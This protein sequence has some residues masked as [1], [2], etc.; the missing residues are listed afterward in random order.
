MA[1]ENIQGCITWERNTKKI[2]YVG[3]NNKIIEVI[4]MEVVD[5]IAIPCLILYIGVASYFIFIYG[6]YRGRHRRITK[7]GD[8]NERLH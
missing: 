3:R 2:I 6:K 7:R 1:R 4:V 8:N 5:I